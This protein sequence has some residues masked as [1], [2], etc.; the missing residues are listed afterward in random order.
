MIGTVNFLETASVGQEIC[1]NGKQAG[2]G[3]MANGPLTSATKSIKIEGLNSA[4]SVWCE[5]KTN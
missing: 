5:I 4:E 1:I 2:S 3:C